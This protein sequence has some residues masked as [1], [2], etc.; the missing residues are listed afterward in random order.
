MGLGVC[1][2]RVTAQALAS[3]GTNTGADPWRWSAASVAPRHPSAGSGP[4]RAGL[5]DGGGA[6]VSGARSVPGPT[7]YHRPSV[8]SM[9]WSASQQLRDTTVSCNYRSFPAAEA[10]K[11]AAF[12]A[13]DKLEAVL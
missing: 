6:R 13:L 2:L 7:G 5:D 12:Y 3:T 1:P 9:A 4:D 11:I 10:Y 8:A